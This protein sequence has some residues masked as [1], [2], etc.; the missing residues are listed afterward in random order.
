MADSVAAAMSEPSTTRMDDVLAGMDAAEV[1]YFN[2]CVKIAVRRSPDTDYVYVVTIIMVP[3]KM[4][5]DFSR[6]ITD[7]PVFVTRHT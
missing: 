1:H 5:E 4:Q 3:F 7:G 2:R 6:P